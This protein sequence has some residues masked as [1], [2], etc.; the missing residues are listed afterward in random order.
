MLN[1]RK[2]FI[3]QLFKQY[4][5]DASA[6]SKLFAEF[7]NEKLVVETF[8]QVQ[9]KQNIIMSHW[10]KKVKL[11]DIKQASLVMPNATAGKAYT[12]TLDITKKPFDDI[13][14]YDV[15][16]PENVGLSY[17]A[18]TNSISGNPLVSGDYTMLFKFQIADSEDWYEKPVR[19]VVNANPKSLWKDLPSN[20]ED[21]YWKADASQTAAPFGAHHIV[22][23]SKRGRSHAH[24]GTYR[25]DEFDYVFFEETGWGV[26][27]VS[28]GAGSAKSSRKGSLIA[29]DAVLDYF[30]SIIPPEDWALMDEAVTKFSQDKN[31]EN[32]KALSQLLIGNLSKAAYGA[33]KTIAEFAAKKEVPIKDFAA[34]LLFSLV[35]KFDFG[36]CIASFGVGDGGIGIYDETSQT[37]SLLTLPDGGE[38]AGQTRFITMPEIFKDD[39][40]FKRFSIKIVEKFTAL[41]W[42]TDG[43]TDPKF[44]TDANLNKFEKWQALW[45][46]LNGQND[47]G[48]KVDFNKDNEQMAEQLSAWLDFWSPGNHDDRTIVV[49][50]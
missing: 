50:F 35:K 31:E 47:D 28:D 16:L 30:T 17:D 8:D 23:A 19:F 1:E 38:F 21:P 9:E 33:H 48:A 4:K 46:D 27:A 20:Q 49:L 34:T 13:V 25:D 40:Y 11:D 12:F 36:Y 37:S 2:G 45:N 14:A 5:V 24:E 39:I 26:V 15:L 43:I 22:A 41:V 42:M 29:C 44:Q 3:E 18:A 6:K 32:S 10:D 7:L